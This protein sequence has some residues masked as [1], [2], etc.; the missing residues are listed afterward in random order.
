MSMLG[1]IAMQALDLPWVQGRD[2]SVLQHMADC[3]TERMGG[4]V[5]VCECGNREVHYNSCRD[6]HCPLCQGSARARWVQSRL[7][8]LLPTPYF[9]VVFTVPHELCSLALSNRR[10][11]YQALFHSAH[12]TLLAVCANPENLG[13]RVG[14]MSILHTWNQK[15]AFHPHLHCIVPG[16]G[17]SPDGT[18][19]I[20]GNPNYLVSVRRLS[21]VFRGKFLGRLE[22]AVRSGELHGEQSI[23]HTALRKAAGHPF[24]VYAKQPFGGPA[25]VVKYLGRYTHRVGMSEQ[26]V[27]SFKDGRV[28]FSWID[29]AHGNTRKLLSLGHDDFIRKFL[30]HVLPK[31]Q[32]KIRYFGYMAN[33]DRSESIAGVRKL[34]ESSAPRPVDTETSPPASDEAAADLKSALTPDRNTCPRCGLHMSI[35]SSWTAGSRST[36]LESRLAHIRSGV[37]IIPG[38]EPDRAVPGMRLPV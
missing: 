22:R 7:G 31:A 21:A 17:V 2:R 20:P 30:L 33:R 15:L 3:Q 6:R 13:G 5:M 29:R 1:D 9:H 38:P 34:I 23:L 19:W 8:E 11:F 4:N 14:G 16:G 26:R 28:C 25:Q 35:Q 32:R 18:G 37:R 12:E 36:C 24:V 27:I 10:F